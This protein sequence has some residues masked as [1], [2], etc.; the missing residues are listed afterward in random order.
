[1]DSK[2]SSFGDK[3]GGGN[4]RN[5]DNNNFFSPKSMI[6]NGFQIKRK[7]VNGI[8][9]GQTK[10][11]KNDNED[12]MK[13]V[14]STSSNGDSFYRGFYNGNGSTNRVF[15]HRKILPVYEVRAA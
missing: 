13:S 5:N 10:K 12:V 11:Q 15:E 7:N 14:A 6:K 2:Y 4:E 8:E 3:S 1:M 9:N